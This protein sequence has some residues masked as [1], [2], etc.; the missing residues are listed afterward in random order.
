MQN[1][2]D[3]AVKFS[4]PQNNPI[5]LNSIILEEK[6]RFEVVDQGVGISPEELPMVFQR[7]YKK[8]EGNPGGSGLGLAIAQE[9]AI[10]HGGD[11]GAESEPGA[12]SCFY[13]TLP[14]AM[15]GVTAP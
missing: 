4:Y 10:Q 9:I 5:T 1:Y 2:I 8:R 7:F 14:I 15:P 12:G 6:V 13:V 3:N 11:V